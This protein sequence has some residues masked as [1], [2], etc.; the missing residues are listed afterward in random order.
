MNSFIIPPSQLPLPWFIDS[1][2]CFPHRL[3][4][5]VE[6]AQQALHEVQ[7]AQVELRVCS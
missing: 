6:F 3:L 2:E 5:L 7:D 4:E 1:K